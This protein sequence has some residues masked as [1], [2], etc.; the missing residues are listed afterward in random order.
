MASLDPAH[1]LVVLNKSDLGS[2]L[3]AGDIPGLKTVRCS[4]ATGQGVDRLKAQVSE[5]I[6]AQPGAPPHAAISSRHRQ[7]VK[8]TLDDL[9]QAI[10]MLACGREDL[11]VPAV[12]WLRSALEALGTATGRVYTDQ[13]L[14]SI[15][16]RFCIGK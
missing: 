7:I 3:S 14:D 13:L 8:Q 16:S 5:A 12:T 15:F 10:E 4:L 6:G 2:T 9:K 11:L 1:T